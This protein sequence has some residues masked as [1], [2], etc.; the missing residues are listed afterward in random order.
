MAAEMEEGDRAL[1]VVAAPRLLRII[2][3][4]AQT[5]LITAGTLGFSVE[6]GIYCRRMNEADWLA[7]NSLAWT[8]EL[9]APPEE[10][11]TE[12]QIY[13]DQIRHHASGT[14]RTMLHLGSGAGGMDALFARHF[15]VTGVDLS[16]GMLEIARRRH[17]GIRYLRGDMRTLRLGERFDVVAIPDAIDYMTSE[18]TLVYLI[19]R[20]GELSIQTDRHELGLFPRDTWKTLF[21]QTELDVE[22]VPLNGIYDQY[23]MD[24]GAYPMALFLGTPRATKGT[25]ATKF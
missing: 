3:L 13:T 10:Y 11:E 20:S 14:P 25:L 5:A 16:S 4:F 21:A 8:D 2:V 18:A 1:S 6:P 7:Y 15:E 9:L 12:V 17:P 24:D 19:R 23:L 22:E